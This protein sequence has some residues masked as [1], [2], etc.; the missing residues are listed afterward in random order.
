MSKSVM[1][2]WM[3][4]VVC[5]LV[6]K[7]VLEIYETVDAEFQKRLDETEKKLETTKMRDLRRAL[8]LV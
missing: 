7:Q 8:R 5:H 1:S 3:L 4:V 2:D 6:L